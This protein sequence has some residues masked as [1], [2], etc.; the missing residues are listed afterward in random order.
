MSPLKVFIIACVLTAAIPTVSFAGDAYLSSGEYV[1]ASNSDAGYDYGT[2]TQD[3]DLFVALMQNM[4]GV[5]GD[6]GATDIKVP[7]VSPF[8]IRDYNHNQHNDSRSGCVSTI[9]DIN[10]HHIKYYVYAL[11]K[12]VI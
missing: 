9:E 12:I 10:I 1:A 8:S 3:N 7:S 6:C 2:Q 11:E 5:S 4:Q